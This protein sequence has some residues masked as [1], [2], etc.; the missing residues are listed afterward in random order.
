[1]GKSGSRVTC[2][3]DGLQWTSLEMGNPASEVRYSASLA[4]GFAVVV[5]IPPK[6]EPMET[7]GN[8]LPRTTCYD[9]SMNRHRQASTWKF[10]CQIARLSKR[11]FFWRQLGGQIAGQSGSAFPGDFEPFRQFTY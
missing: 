8:S 11:E 6:R 5:G 10:S 7:P 3:R 2:C 4:S 1:F 9:P